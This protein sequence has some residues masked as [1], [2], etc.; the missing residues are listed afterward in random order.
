MDAGSA[1]LM[2]RVAPEGEEW[3]PGRDYTITRLLGEEEGRNSIVR[4]I[5]HLRCETSGVRWNLC[6]PWEFELAFCSARLRQAYCIARARER[7]FS[8]FLG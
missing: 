3:L 6:E 1:S 7:C 4:E 2:A 8:Q 5:L